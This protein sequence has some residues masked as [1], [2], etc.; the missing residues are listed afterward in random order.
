M[1]LLDGV[2]GSVLGGAQS[3]GQ[4]T[5]PMGALLGS[6]LG[7]Q[8]TESNPLLQIVLTLVQQSGGLPALLEKLKNAGLAEHVASWVGTGTNLPVSGEQVTQALGSQAIGQIASQLGMQ[9]NIASGALASL[10]PELVN[11]MTPEG[12]VPHNHNDLVAM[13]LGALTGR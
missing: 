10:L 2:L 6:L 5:D 11:K 9:P 13:A 4:S 3:Q 7:G 12:A 1:G 8:K